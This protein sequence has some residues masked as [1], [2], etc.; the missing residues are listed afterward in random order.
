VT[1]AAALMVA[2]VLLSLLGTIIAVTNQDIL[3]SV[4]EASAEQQGASGATP[5]VDT[6]VTISL[7]TIIGF[8][9]VIAIAFL[10][11]TLFILRG[12]NVARIITWVVCGLFLCCTGYS[13]VSALSMQDVE[14]PGWYTA[15][16]TA[17]AL[18]QLLIYIGVIVLLALPPSNSYFKPKPQG[19]LY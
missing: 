2:Q 17:S 11:L 4:A 15:F 18:I 3:R 8:A 7:V 9:L 1:L 19:Q 5:S 16:S 10:V 14:L 12:S 6:L 13:G